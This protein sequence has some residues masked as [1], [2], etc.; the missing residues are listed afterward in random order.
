MVSADHSVRRIPIWLT[1]LTAALLILGFRPRRFATREVARGETA[2][3]ADRGRLA[4]TPAQIPARGWKDILWRVYNR[5]TECRVVAVAAGVT[6]YALLAI[7]PAIAALISIYGLF[8]DPG[9]IA[10]HLDSIASFIPGGAIEVIRDQMNR[11]ASQ[12]KGTLGLAFL[13]GLGISLWSAN[14]GIKALFDA[15][16]IVHGE[17]EKR[18]FIRLNLASLGFTLAAIVFL[19]LALALIAVAP[20]ALEYIGL[21]SATEWI[22]KISRW[23]L[24]FVIIS[25]ALSILYRYGPSRTQPQWR[26]VTFGSVIAAPLWIAISLL[27]SWYAE[28]FGSYNKTYGSLGA[29]IGF[30]TWIWLSTIVML[31]GAAINAEMEHQTVRDTTVNASKPMGRRGA[32]MADTVGAAQD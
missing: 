4:E 25:L 26:W 18:S 8:A 22:I 19:L 6:F 27:F 15:L 32:K 31:V 24:L 16:N 28:N 1:A 7:F 21:E 23:P 3:E 12:G 10:S 11:L 2:A 9:T 5:I 17:K 29:I 20:V 14:A 13:V 30:M